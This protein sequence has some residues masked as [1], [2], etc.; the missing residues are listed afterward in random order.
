MLN[1]V[2]SLQVAADGNPFDGVVAADVMSALVAC[3]HEDE[4]VGQAT[5][6]FLRFRL[7]SCPV[8]DASNRLSG[9]LSEKDVIGAMTDGDCWIKPVREVMRRNVV[10]YEEETPVKTIYD[11]L[12]RVAIRRVIVVRDGEPTGIISRGTLLRWYR[13]WLSAHD[14]QVDTEGEWSNCQGVSGL[15]TRQ[16]MSHTATAIAHEAV[17]L[18]EA[19]SGESDDCLPLLIDRA[20]KIQELI[21]DV[22]GDSRS[23]A[24][25]VEG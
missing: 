11:F 25:P 1:E 3:L 18:R 24:S 8:V 14:R 7:N 2:E 16:R 22:L 21:N 13:N 9:I 5:D 17:A 20:S 12:C 19:L 10:F 15:T 23:L 4:T 6:F